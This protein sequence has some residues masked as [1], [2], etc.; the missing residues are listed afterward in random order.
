M[1]PLRSLLALGRFGVGIALTGRATGAYEDRLT[2]S[3]TAE[4][5]DWGRPVGVTVAKSGSLLVLD[6]GPNTLGRVTYV[7]DSS[8]ANGR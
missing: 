8:G 6:D 2:V 3:V 4:G 7:A 5:K 1:S